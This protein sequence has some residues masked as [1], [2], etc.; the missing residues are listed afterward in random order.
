MDEVVTTFLAVL[1]VMFLTGIASAVLAFV[2]VKKK[3]HP[4]ISIILS[5]VCWLGIVIPIR[6]TIGFFFSRISMLSVGVYSAVIIIKS[7]KIMKNRLSVD[8][9]I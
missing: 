6:H 7:V 3:V 5:V 8:K 2:F 9:N 1:G 4:V